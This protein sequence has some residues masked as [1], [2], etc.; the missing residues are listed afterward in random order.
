MEILRYISG[1]QVHHWKTLVAKS[2][3][4]T[5]V[6]VICVHLSVPLAFSR[7]ENIVDPHTTQE[8]LVLGRYTG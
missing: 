5:V 4:V 6:Q 1:W 3:A 2:R 7:V 8:G